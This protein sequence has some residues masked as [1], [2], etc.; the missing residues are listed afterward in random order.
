MQLPHMVLAFPEHNQHVS[1]LRNLPPNRSSWF[2]PV[3]SHWPHGFHPVP[4]HTGH[5]AEGLSFPKPAPRSS[6]PRSK[7]K[8]SPETG[9]Q[10][11]H[12]TPSPRAA[13]AETSRRE[14]EGFFLD[15]PFEKR[16]KARPP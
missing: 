5:R 2:T 3:P 15:A 8:P 16:L 10:Q 12:R 13:P 6:L 1:P 14:G 7:P 4:L 11:R 9:G